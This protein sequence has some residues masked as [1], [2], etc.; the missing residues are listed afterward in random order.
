MFGINLIWIAAVMTIVTGFDY[1][2]A[3]IRH[4]MSR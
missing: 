1:L 3:G 2:K 4:A